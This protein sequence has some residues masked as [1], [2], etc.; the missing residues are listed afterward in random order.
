M[1]SLR[2]NSGFTLIE[3][4]LVIAILGILA[5]AVMPQVINISATALANQRNAIAGSVRDGINLQFAD[6][7]VAGSSSY[8]SA[9]DTASNGSCNSS[10]PCF[11]NV[12]QQGGVSSGWTKNGT[13]YTHDDTSTSY[14]YNSV[15]GSFQ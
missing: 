6:N 5:I 1:K 9:L 11:G 3:L 7:L 8:P 2:N 10:N 14:S 12:L 4:I 13:Q 15:T